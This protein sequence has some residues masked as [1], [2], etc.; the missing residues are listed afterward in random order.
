MKTEFYNTIADTVKS[1]YSDVLAIYLFGSYGT[2]Y[3]RIDSDVD[4]AVLLPHTS[5]G[6]A[7][8]MAVSECRM[9]LEQYLGKEVD[10]VNLRLAPVVL[11]KEIV[12]QAVRIA[13]ADEFVV[14]MFETGVL[15]GYQKFSAER[16]DIMAQGLKTGRFYQP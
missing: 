6:K 7:R 9:V 16:A 5:A 12:M 4:L 3:E 11:Q 10:L 8:N 1:Y 13:T 14:E 15:S 2:Q